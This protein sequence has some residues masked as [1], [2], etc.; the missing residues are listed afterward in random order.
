[1]VYSQNPKVTRPVGTQL[2][3]D[4]RSEG[5]NVIHGQGRLTS[6][7]QHGINTWLYSGGRCRVSI[8]SG[9]HSDLVSLVNTM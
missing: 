6:L 7:T 8:S 2:Y 4:T 9:E 5:F 1:L 3:N